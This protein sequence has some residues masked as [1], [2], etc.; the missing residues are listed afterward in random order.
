MRRGAWA[1][2]RWLEGGGGVRGTGSG[3]QGG[4][5]ASGAAGLVELEHG[6][7]FGVGRVEGGRLAVLV[8]EL[9]GALIEV[10]GEFWGARAGE[11]GGG[12]EGRPRWSRIAWTGSSGVR[13][14]MMRS[15]P[16][17]LEQSKG[18]SS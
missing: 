5:F 16:P 17:Q 1:A 14:A 2:G 15:G 12:R 7:R 9:G 18:K 6:D 10:E 4:C 3:W 11:S 8:G 13:K